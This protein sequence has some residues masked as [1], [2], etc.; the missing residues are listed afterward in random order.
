MAYSWF[1]WLAV[2]TT[3]STGE[4]QLDR[5]I[6]CVIQTGARIQEHN[7]LG[8]CKV[9]TTGRT[10]AAVRPPQLRRVRCSVRMLPLSGHMSPVMLVKVGAAAG[11]VAT[12]VL[13][14]TGDCAVPGPIRL[15][16]APAA[17]F[18]G[19]GGEGVAAARASVPARL[20]TRRLQKR[21]QSLRRGIDLEPPS[22]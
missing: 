11:L 13:L 20:L 2:I 8:L 22:L 6:G 10:A 19:I 14:L 16:L 21:P 3:F 12:P 17:A 18:Q 4:Q 1:V 15:V 5:R 7:V 9:L